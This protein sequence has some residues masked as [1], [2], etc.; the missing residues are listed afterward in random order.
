MFYHVGR[1]WAGD[2]LIRCAC[3]ITPPQIITMWNNT[4]AP[5]PPN[6]AASTYSL[7]LT[8]KSWPWMWIESP[9]CR[10]KGWLDLFNFSLYKHKSI[11]LVVTS[12]QEKT[13]CKHPLMF[14]QKGRAYFS[15][16]FPLSLVVL[17][18]CHKLVIIWHILEHFTS[19]RTETQIPSLIR[20]YWVIWWLAIQKL[21]KFWIH[22]IKL[23]FLR[24]RIHFKSWAL[25]YYIWWGIN[26]P[27]M[28]FLLP[29]RNI[30]WA[31]MEELCEKTL[32]HLSWRLFFFFNSLIISGKTK[33]LCKRD[34]LCIIL[35]DAWLLK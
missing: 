1:A 35:I 24:R 23:C 5:P 11:L 30:I 13:D 29:E 27:D 21:V 7:H 8:H 25:H 34:H 20:M 9:R 18:W 26:L 2:T 31:S 16:V 12:K 3:I 32:L 6:L 15:R 17:R 4:P 14:S 33:I 22:T 28:F 19:L 10:L